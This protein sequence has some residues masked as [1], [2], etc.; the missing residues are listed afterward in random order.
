[1][2][3]TSPLAQHA[4]YSHGVSSAQRRPDDLAPGADHERQ[5]RNITFAFT[6]QTGSTA[7]VTFQCAL[8]EG[9][10]T[11][12]AASF[13]TCSSPVVYSGLQN[14]A[15]QFFVRAQGEDLADSSSFFLVSYRRV[16]CL[17]RVVV[18]H[19]AKIAAKAVQHLHSA[20][21]I[22]ACC[23]SPPGSLC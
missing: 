18:W 22:S 3:S 9:N 19:M 8:V 17:A 2:C 11:E 15:W 5:C 10:Q 6:T 23:T 12:A 14:G 16:I 4:R 13:E 7:G 1:M 21:C 20:C